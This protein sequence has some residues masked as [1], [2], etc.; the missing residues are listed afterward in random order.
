MGKL[1]IWIAVAAAAWFAWKFYQT[2][3]RRI[4]QS[5]QD[6]APDA[7]PDG[8]REHQP[9]PAQRA[10]ERMIACAHCGVHLPASEASAD[11]AGRH[12]C[13]RAHLEAAK[14]PRP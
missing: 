11:E 12:Y 7:A 2:S 14:R 3:Q 6:A 1:L 4:Q 10:P 13:S 9:D 8:A 5:R